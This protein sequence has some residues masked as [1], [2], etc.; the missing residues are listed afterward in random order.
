M[1]KI[2][3][4]KELYRRMRVSGVRKRVAR[5]LAG[6]PGLHSD[7]KRAPKAL[8]DAVD[9][10]EKVTTELRGHTTGVERKAGARKAARTR[11]ASAQH[12][13]GTTPRRTTR[14]PPAKRR[15]S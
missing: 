4:D 1:A 13:R 10:L 14:K 2:K 12:R 5:E 15:R 3:G 8:R 6:L 11:Q 9:R 7:G